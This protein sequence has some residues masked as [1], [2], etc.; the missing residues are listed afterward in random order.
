M[1]RQG[2]RL[3][4]E[5]GR[6]VLPRG[7]NLS[8]SAKLPACPPPGSPGDRFTN[9]REVSFVGR[10]FPLDEAD[11]HFRRLQAWG[12]R[13]LRW[14]VTW[15]ALEHAGPGIYD[16]EYLDYLE[17]VIRK[18]GE[19]GFDL[20][21]DPHQDM[22]SRFTGGSGAP[23][24]TLEAAGFDM[25]RFAQT[26]AAV[27][28]PTPGDPYPQM[29]WLTNSERLAPATMFT[30]FF[31]GND[32]APLTRIDG[33]LAQEFLQR[34]YIA[35]FTQLAARLR[36]CSHVAG[37]GV[38]NEP[39]HGLIGH[40]DLRK[41]FRD[42][43]PGLSPTP[44]Q[45]MLLAAGHPQ[46]VDVIGITPLGIRRIGK[47]L[48]DPAAEC[49][50]AGC[51]AG[52]WREHGVWEAGPDGRPALLQ[53]DYFTRA[54]GQ[55]IDFNQDYY[56][57]F[58]NRFG[59]AIRQAHPDSL[60]FI[61]SELGLRMPR[62]GP[63][64]IEQ[65]VY[66]PHWYDVVS[67]YLKQYSPHLAVDV[68]GRGRLVVGRRNIRRSFA[69]QLG[70]LRQAAADE[71][72]GAPVLLG[73]TGIP[74]DLHR[75]RSFLTGDFTAQLAALDRTLTAVQDNLI[76]CCLWNYTPDNTHA[77][78]DHWNDE[79]LS[80]FCR[81]QQTD[82]NDIH[83]GGR[84]LEALLRPH[85]IAIAGE[86]TRWRYDLAA[87]R[88]EFAFRSLPTA[89]PESEFYLPRFTYAHGVKVETSGGRVDLDLENQVLCYYHDETQAEHWIRIE[90]QTRR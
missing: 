27:V 14:V 85:P 29:V 86:P 60:I 74:F 36:S 73:E 42:Y 50:W 45:S 8:G 38:M 5:W 11:E 41:R 25:T 55:P 34:R 43:Q 31:G 53:P 61:H 67:V 68:R 70:E 64:D 84:G 2:S 59:R 30:L 20:Y 69:A 71:L 77:R 15:E 83:S 90:P 51:A 21:I 65:I 19:Y 58:V 35:A 33:E 63:G 76:G 39:L 46:W 16:Q 3:V 28:A 66:A 4:D 13:L 89:R 80:I 48:V 22:W 37:Y 32:F 17:A 52:I 44:F 56:R 88:F 81:D 24:W 23:G 40:P 47:R 79:D 9:H 72:A 26:G 49:A 6:T 12:F 10:P 57:P 87:R 75:K 62:W 82:P 1:K 78:G 7:I 54:A 18:A